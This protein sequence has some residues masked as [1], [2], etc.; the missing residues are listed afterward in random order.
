MLL[1][2]S[3]FGTSSLTGCTNPPILIFIPGTFHNQCTTQTQSGN[4]E[5]KTFG[6]QWIPNLN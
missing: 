5:C 1:G 2:F 4:K 6:F 3:F